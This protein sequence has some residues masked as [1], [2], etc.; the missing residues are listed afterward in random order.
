MD[1]GIPRLV[2]NLSKSLEGTTI[3]LGCGFAAKY[4]RGGGN[5]SVPLQWVLGLRR[6][7][8]DGIWLEL[9]P[10]TKDRE[11]DLRCIQNFQVQL[12]KHGLADRY[13]LL[14]QDPTHDSHDLNTMQCFGISK[15]MLLER[16]LGPNILLNLSYSIHPPFLL[17]FERR[18]FC[19]LDPGEISYWMSKLE[20]GQSF[21]HD[22]WT[23]GLNKNSPDCGLPKSP[24]QWKTFYP[25]VDTQL[26]Q[27][28][29]PPKKTRF[30]TISQWYWHQGIEVDGAYP[31]LSKQAAFQKFIDLP[32]LVPE[33]AMELALNLNPDDPEIQRIKNHNWKL[34]VPHDIAATPELYRKY[35][36]DSS[37]EF[38]ACKGVDVH[39]QT[40]WVSD[41]AAAYLATGRPVITE[42]TGIR[43]YLPEESGFLWV[44]NLEEARAAIDRVSK[45][46]N[47]LSKQA[48]NCAVEIFDSAKNLS[49][50]LES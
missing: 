39:W 15:E 31:D 27:P 11:H 28:M 24:V 40:G 9:M 48:R 42:D 38:T 12:E 17:Q 45:D 26:H 5:F 47:P 7:N 29:P 16:L 1:Y 50:I 33:V 25:L 20:M 30:T 36:A 13:C 32:S 49:R 22:F 43:R 23:I 10:A 37:A 6:L 35:I 46:W 4:L 14:Y 18:I 19:D 44:K 8:L 21:H 2:M 3:F 41:R 34:A